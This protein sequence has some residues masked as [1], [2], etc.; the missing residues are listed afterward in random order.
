[1]MQNQYPYAK[2]HLEN[3][4]D[5]TIEPY[6]WTKIGERKGYKLTK[7]R[8]GMYGLPFTG[9]IA[10]KLLIDHL[11]PYGYCPCRLTPDYG[12][13]RTDQSDLCY[14]STI[15]ELNTSAKTMLST[16]SIGYGNATP[17]QWTGPALYYWGSNSSGTTRLYPL[18]YICQVTSKKLWKCFSIPSQLDPNTRPIQRRIPSGYQTPN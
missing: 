14:A 1:M 13:I 17:S 11:A 6:K 12:P 9:K 5:D 15:S 3:I 18:I 10:Y 4:S 2:E 16:C 8:R 7:I